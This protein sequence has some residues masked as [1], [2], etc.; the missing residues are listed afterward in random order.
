VW[1]VLEG[2]FAIVPVVIFR[3]VVLY[4]MVL[5][6]FRLMGKRTLGEMQP[7]D[8][9]IVISIAE[10]IG[11]PLAEPKEVQMTAPI[12]AII[13]LALT[14][15]ALAYAALKSKTV[16]YL[17]EGKATLIVKNGQAIPQN[18][19][20]MKYNMDDLTEHLRMKGLR[21]VVDVEFAYLEP[22]GTLSVILKKT[23]EPVT[24]R[25]LGETAS[26]PLIHDGRLDRDKLRDAGISLDHLRG[27]LAAR[28][29]GSIAD[30]E[31]AYLDPTGRLRVEKQRRSPEPGAKGRG[32]RDRAGGGAGRGATGRERGNQAGIDAA[33]KG[34]SRDDPRG[35]ANK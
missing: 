16:R 33:S 8:F 23:A 19:A 18:M 29:I 1:P 20:R 25:F 32:G 15:V 24:P 17:V 11:E 5:L 10:I 31:M 3:A 22:N 9:V 30:V 34:K 2:L 28:G 12:V 27:M 14:Q 7:H 6:L 21:S 4:A 13:T 26:V 35:P